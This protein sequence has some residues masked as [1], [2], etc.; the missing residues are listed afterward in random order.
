[1]ECQRIV[2]QWYQQNNDCAQRIIGSIIRRKGHHGEGGD[3][4]RAELNYWICQHVT[5]AARQG[6]IG[7]VVLS[8]A[9]SYAYLKWASGKRSYQNRQGR[10]NPAKEITTGCMGE[11]WQFPLSKRP[12]NPAIRARYHLDMQTIGKRLSP[13]AQRVLREFITDPHATDK[14]VCEALGKGWHRQ[15]VFYYRQLIK[16]ALAD[17]GY[18]PPP[19][20][21]VQVPPKIYS[22]G[23]TAACIYDACQRT[24]RAS[25]VDIARRLGCRNSHVRWAVHRFAAMGV[26]WAMQFMEVNA[27]GRC[28]QPRGISFD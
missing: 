24:P 20:R 4:M 28:Q 6:A 12:E 3:E 10:L 27:Q 15:Y 23:R 9:I 21:M 1:V 25:Y 16:R 17:A 11:E 7:K 5:S 2:E 26:P 18:A 13:K 22:I 14:S 8:M 19:M